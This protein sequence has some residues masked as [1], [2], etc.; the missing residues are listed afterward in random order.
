M[1]QE[2]RSRFSAA[3]EQSKKAYQETPVPQ[4][5]SRR[6]ERAIAWGWRPSLGGIGAS[7]PEGWR[8]DCAPASCWP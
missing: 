4:D 8:P 2:K 7:G 5:L 3:M 6:M 1:E